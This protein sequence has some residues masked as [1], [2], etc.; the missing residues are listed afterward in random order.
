M[1]Q[2]LVQTKINHYRIVFEGEKKEC[3]EY[4]KNN[5]KIDFK[6]RHCESKELKSFINWNII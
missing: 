6:W 3:I 1:Y 4:M 5:P 2:V